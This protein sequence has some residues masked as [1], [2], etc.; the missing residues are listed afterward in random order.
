[1][2][3]PVVNP[4]SIEKNAHLD[5][6]LLGAESQDPHWIVLADGRPVGE[7][8]LRDQ[9]EP[10]KVA[11]LFVTEQYADSVREA[12]RRFSFQEVLAGVRGRPYVAAVAGA[13]AYRQVEASVKAEAK[14][15]LRKA[16][17][18]LRDNMLNLLNLVVHAQSKNFIQANPLKEEMFT[19]MTDAGVDNSRAVSIIEA[20]YQAKA[21]DHF[22]ACFKQASKWMDLQPEAL[23]ELEEQIRGFS[24]RTPVVAAAE[25]IPAANIHNVPLHTYRD[26][27]FEGNAE[28]DDKA[29]LKAKMKLSMRR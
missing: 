8:R 2:V 29:S 16:K 22:E 27:A 9:E 3:A 13:D 20:A 15:E 11:S 18:D 14:A 1:M 5:M 23:A 25:N 21:A 24:H 7:I 4:S 28:V 6:L 10:E 26:A 12:A 17:A 19:R